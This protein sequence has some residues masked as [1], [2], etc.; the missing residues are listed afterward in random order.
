MAART[1]DEGLHHYDGE[2]VQ[3]LQS[4]CREFIL[5][6]CTAGVY[7]GPGEPVL[8]HSGSAAL[9]LIAASAGEFTGGAVIVL[10]AVTFHVTIVR[11]KEW[12]AATHCTNRGTRNKEHQVISHR[13]R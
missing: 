11:G 2:R 13:A 12:A 4:L 5:F 7:A 9:K 1:R 3:Q 8:T 6:T 10:V